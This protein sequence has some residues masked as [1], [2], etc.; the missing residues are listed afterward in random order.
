MLS[1]SAFAADTNRYVVL[2]L[3]TSGS[4]RG[5]PAAVQREAAK[6]FC[7]QVLTAQ[8]NNNV[9]LV[10]LNTRASVVCQFTNDFEE[11]TSKIDI[12]GASGGTNIY[13][14]L[15]LADELLDAVAV[16]DAVKNVVLCSDGLP[17]NGKRQE[18]G[19]YNSNDSDFYGQANAAHS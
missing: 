17:E 15:E 5:E 19:H 1:C 3:D 9:A 7:Q 12:F 11:L 2:I 14:T 4:M 16:S 13:A 18:E 10:S 8:G 6:K